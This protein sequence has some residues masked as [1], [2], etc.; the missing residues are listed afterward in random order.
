MAAERCHVNRPCLFCWIWT[1]SVLH[2]GLQDRAA[3]QIGVIP[4]HD[5]TCRCLAGPVEEGESGEKIEFS[6]VVHMNVTKR[7]LKHR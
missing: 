3:I 7:H 2:I 6:K 4:A 5:D 1:C